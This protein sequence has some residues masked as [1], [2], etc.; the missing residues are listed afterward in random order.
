LSIL[1]QTTCVSMWHAWS[2]LK[3]PPALSRRALHQVLSFGASSWRLLK[4]CCQPLP[5]ATPRCR[6]NQSRDLSVVV[7]VAALAV[8]GS[9]SRPR[10]ASV[11]G[12]SASCPRSAGDGAFSSSPIRHL[13]TTRAASNHGASFVALQL[14]V[15]I[16]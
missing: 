12:G 15:A 3:L 16:Q 2:K 4:F 6:Q 8:G 7:E 9:A 10:S 11:V 5:H 13:I 1:Y 14:H